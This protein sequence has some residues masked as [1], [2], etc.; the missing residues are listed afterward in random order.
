MHKYRA[1]MPTAS[2][3][4]YTLVQHM[5]MDE[6]YETLFSSDD[7][8]NEDTTSNLSSVEAEWGRYNSEP[9]ETCNSIL[10]Y[11]SVT[12]LWLYTFCAFFS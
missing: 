12:L 3:Q 4:K 5:A 2:A 7:D 1:T 6:A 9:Q 11:W 10:G 8:E